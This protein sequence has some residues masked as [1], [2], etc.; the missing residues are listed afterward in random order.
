MAV[1]E[2]HS[3]EGSVLAEESSLLTTGDRFM[4]SVWL[5]SNHSLIPV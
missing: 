1:I 2:H 3:H 4:D 5:G